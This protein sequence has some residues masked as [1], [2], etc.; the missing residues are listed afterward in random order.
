[1]PSISTAPSRTD[2]RDGRAEQ[3]LAS[4]RLGAPARSANTARN[5]R[6]ELCRHQRWT[7]ARDALWQVLNPLLT[8]M[9]RIGV[10]GAGNGDTIP[11]DRIAARARQ[12][13]LIDLD[14]TRSAPLATCSPADDAVVST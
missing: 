5:A 2:T 6:A 12:T 3:A 10:L 1:M 11:L 9:T 4:L 13:T 7:T 14:G 8:D